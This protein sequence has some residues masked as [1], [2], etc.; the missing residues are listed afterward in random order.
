[1]IEI[2]IRLT[3]GGV[4]Q[5]GADETA[6]NARAGFRE[7]LQKGCITLVMGDGKSRLIPAHAI[8]HIDITENGA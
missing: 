7:Q 2:L 5:T 4:V 3:D 1:M 6:Q 8:G